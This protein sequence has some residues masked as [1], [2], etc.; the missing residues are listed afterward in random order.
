MLEQE[1]VTAQ[2]VPWMSEI[3]GRLELQL[4]GWEHILTT[5]NY[6]GTWGVHMHILSLIK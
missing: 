4:P 3:V 1:P 5:L 2:Q 6:S